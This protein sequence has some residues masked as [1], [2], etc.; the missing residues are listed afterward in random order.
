VKFGRITIWLYWVYPDSSSYPFSM[1]VDKVEAKTFEGVIIWKTLDAITK[2]LGLIKE[3]GHLKFREY[4]ALKGEDQIELPTNYQATLYENKIEGTVVPKRETDVAVTFSLEFAG[5]NSTK[6]GLFALNSF[7]NASK[8]KF[9]LVTND[10]G[11]AFTISDQQTAFKKLVGN[12][13][14]W[15]DRTKQGE[16]QPR[17]REQLE[18]EGYRKSCPVCGLPQFEQTMTGEPSKTVI[19]CQNYPHCFNQEYYER[20]IIFF[21]F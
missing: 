13:E 16:L 8:R 11:E 17:S 14:Y 2:F 19:A 15:Y 20:Y 18:Q 4:E 3:N 9:N 1:R 10:S 21:D 6:E 5:I 7:K 12:S